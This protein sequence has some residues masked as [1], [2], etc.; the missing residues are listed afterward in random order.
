MLVQI[1]Q[2]KKYKHSSTNY[3]IAE[4]QQKSILKFSED[5]LN[6]TILQIMENKNIS[7]LLNEVM[8]SKFVIRK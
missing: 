8:G 3:F 5:L 1:Y 6:V 2:E 7:N 4:K